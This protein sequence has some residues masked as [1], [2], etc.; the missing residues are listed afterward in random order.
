MGAA[1]NTGALTDYLVEPIDAEEYE[2]L[3]QRVRSEQLARVERRH[4]IVSLRIKG[5]TADQISMALERGDDGK[6]PIQVAPSKVH[7]AINRYVEELTQLDRETADAL[8]VIDNHRLEQMYRRL[9]L[10]ASS[11]NPKTKG[12]AIRAQLQVLE[13]HAKLNGLDAAQRHRIEG[14]VEHQLV[15]AQEHVAKVEAEFRER[16]D[17]VLELPAAEVEDDGEDGPPR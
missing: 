7:A 13:R 8:R 2:S 4:R 3:G 11:N 17:P 1:R 10:D 9:E 16:G 12:L 15:A 14:V 5:F 6:E